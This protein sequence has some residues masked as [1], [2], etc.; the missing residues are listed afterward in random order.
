[1]LALVAMVLLRGD[2][3][4]DMDP[5]SP[6][7]RV[8]LC[9]DIA[10]SI[11]RLKPRFDQ[12]AEFSDARNV[13]ADGVI[14]YDYKT[15]PSVVRGGW[16]SGWP[17]A[18]SDGIALHIDIWDESDPHRS[19][20][21]DQRAETRPYARIGAWRVTFIM[22][23]G[24]AVAPV[25]DSVYQILLAKGLRVG[26]PITLPSLPNP[27]TVR[28]VVLK[29][30]YPG[31]PPLDEK[32]FNTMLASAKPISPVDPSLSACHNAPRYTGQFSTDAGRY[33]FE[34]FIGGRGRLTTPAGEFGYF[35]TSFGH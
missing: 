25:Y 31:V 3:T 20:L 28:E 21:N 34:L 11:E 24:N 16:R 13:L 27:A 10:R 9:H 26:D 8:Q 7:R 4:V 12:L 18:N 22:S 2:A 17:V 1:M 35:T 23:E 19:Q 5:G 14:S 33:Y 6:T 29:A 30:F 32:Q 15:H